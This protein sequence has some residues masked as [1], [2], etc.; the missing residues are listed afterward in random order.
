[1]DRMLVLVSS[2][3]LHNIG[4]T[5]QMVHDL[6]LPS[7]IFNILLVHQFPFGNG[8]T[9]ELFAGGFKGAE[10]SYAKLASTKFFSNGVEGLDILHGTAKDIADWSSLGWF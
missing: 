7:H 1:M 6:N 4:L 3:E 8:L 5:S 2:L 10:M 9:G